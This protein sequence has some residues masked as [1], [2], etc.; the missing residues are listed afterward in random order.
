VRTLASIADYAAI[1]L[2]NARNFQRIQELTVVDEHTGLFNARHLQRQL[3]V[4]LIRARR[5]NQPI[6]ILF[7]DLDHFKK[8]NDTHGHQHGSA[9]L[10]EAGQLLVKQLRTVDI[11]VRYGGDEFVVLLPQT[12]RAQATICAWRLREAVSNHTFLASE[13]LA[14]H[15]TASLGVAAFPQDASSGDDLMRA[16]DLAMYRA[17]EAGR[18]QVCGAA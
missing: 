16:A 13:G 8:V 5:F 1:A 10:R 15:L 18:D 12:D 4:E 11:P 9:L 2:E 17:K 7:L 6:A 3:E 14:V